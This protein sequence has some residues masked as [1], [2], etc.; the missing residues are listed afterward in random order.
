MQQL[1]EVCFVVGQYHMVAMAMNS[2]GVVP[3]HGDEASLPGI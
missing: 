2:L 3:D 1:I